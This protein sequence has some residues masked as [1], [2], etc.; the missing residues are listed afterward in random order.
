MQVCQSMMIYEHDI[1][2][3]LEVSHKFIAKIRFPS[4]GKADLRGVRFNRASSIASYHGKD[5]LRLGVI[6]LC[7]WTNS[8]DGWAIVSIRWLGLTLVSYTYYGLGRCGRLR[9]LPA[10]RSGVIKLFQP[11]SWWVTGL[12]IYSK[13]WHWPACAK[14]DGRMTC[15]D[16]IL[17]RVG[18]SIGTRLDG[19]ES[20][21][22]TSQVPRWW[23]WRGESAI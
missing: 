1:I 8:H 19:L 21:C 11:I 18:G 3:R 10:G 13:D 9:S 22:S 5:Y 4:C 23:W 15:H 7:H 2:T 20:V 12:E 17:T 6:W 16:L 14:H